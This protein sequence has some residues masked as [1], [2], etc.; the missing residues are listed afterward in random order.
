[1]RL[2]PLVGRL[3]RVAGEVI[4]QELRRRSRRGGESSRPAGTGR[5]GAVDVG[6]APSM[7]GDADPG[8]VVWT[9]VPYEEDP[10]KGKDRP[11]LVVGLIGSR[12]AAVPLT[13][14]HHPERGD[15]V[16]VGTGPWDPRQRPSYADVSRLL[17]LDPGNV[18]REG[19]ALSRD[20]FDAVVRAARSRHPELA[21]A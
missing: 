5:G 13:S 9:W 3:A 11:V 16:P 21:G 2:G 17:R 15:Q 14:K 12:L 1:M 18:R 6:Y 4:Q 19:S 10:S 7:D 20:R 8:E